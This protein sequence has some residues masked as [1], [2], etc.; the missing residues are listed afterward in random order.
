MRRLPKSLRNYS[1]S[2]YDCIFLEVDKAAG[3]SPSLPEEWLLLEQL[4]D[5]PVPT[6]DGLLPWVYMGLEI[7]KIQ[8]CLVDLQILSLACCC[9]YALG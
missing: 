8:L 4:R 6:V 2:S 7:L 1:N 9:Q 5:S 3:L